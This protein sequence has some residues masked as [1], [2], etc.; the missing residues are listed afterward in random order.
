MTEAIY[1]KRAPWTPL[2]GSDNA[3]SCVIMLVG[4]GF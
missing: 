1:R 4:G 3:L 2:T